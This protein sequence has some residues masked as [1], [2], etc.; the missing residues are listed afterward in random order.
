MFRI[1][2]V[3]PAKMA[4]PPLDRDNFDADYNYEVPVDPVSGIFGD[5]TLLDTLTI[6]DG[7]RTKDDG[8]VQIN[9]NPVRHD[10]G[11]GLYNINAGPY[12]RNVRFANNTASTGGG[13]YTHSGAPVLQEVAF[14]SNDAT[15]YGTNRGNGA[16]FAAGGGHPVLI[17][18][19]FRNNATI[20][21]DG[22]G[23]YAAGGANVLVKRCRF[24]YNVTATGSGIANYGNIW[25]FGR[26]SPSDPEFSNNSATDGGAAVYNGGTMK[27]AGV[28]T[29]GNDILNSGTLWA[30]GLESAGGYVNNG[31]SLR[32]SSVTMTN[33]GISNSGG[34]AL[35]NSTLTSSQISSS[36][37]SVTV[38][39]NSV[40]EGAGTGVSFSVYQG[41]PDPAPPVV[42]ACVLT[43]V[44]IKNKSTGVSAAYSSS[45]SFHDG[46]ANL[47]LNNVSITGCTTA[48]DLRQ[49][50]PSSFLNGRKGLY[51]TLNNVSIAG[52]GLN[53]Q[54]SGI[55]VPG[56]SSANN[57]AADGVDLS[58]GAYD[59]LDLRI[60]NS[61]IWKNGAGA[62]LSANEWPLLGTFHSDGFLTPGANTLFFAR[63]AAGLFLPGD[64]FRIRGSD[65]RLRGSVNTV[66]SVNG[67]TGEVDLMSWWP[68]N[69]GQETWAA[70]DFIVPTGY[71]TS[72]GSAGSSGT[73][74]PGTNT[75][76]LTAAQLALMPPG[77]LFKLAQNYNDG[78]AAPLVNRVTAADAASG[79]ITFTTEGGGTQNYAAGWHILVNTMRRGMSIGSWL[80]SAGNKWTL[81]PGQVSM[82]SLNSVFHP[83]SGGRIGPACTVTDISGNTVTFDA[84][85]AASY[86]PNRTLLLKTS[87]TVTGLSLAA[88]IQQSLGPLPEADAALFVPGMTFRIVDPAGNIGASVNT[89]DSVTLAGPASEV[90]FTPS[91]DAGPVSGTL[92]IEIPGTIGNGN[93]AGGTLSTASPNTLVLDPVLASLFSP[94][95]KFRLV[96]VSPDG[97]PKTSVNETSSVSGNLLTFSA[98]VGNSWTAGDYIVFEGEK[99]ADLRGH[100]LWE[101]SLAEGIDRSVAGGSL[102]PS[103]ELMDADVFAPAY[104]PGAALRDRGTGGLNP[105]SGAAPT[106]RVTLLL[107]HCFESYAAR[108]ASSAAAVGALGGARSGIKDLVET[109]LYRWDPGSEV[110]VRDI[111]I[112][113]FLSL[114]GTINGTNSRI[115][116]TAIDI[117]AY[118]N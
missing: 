6:Q 21:G 43:N 86:V 65:G 30:A 56:P 20:G 63:H 3:S 69:S 111:D 85:S 106:D 113:D 52:A 57:Y 95:D 68:S 92:M 73:L 26:G 91:L 48:I 7:L 101:T 33:A 19:D 82:L 28:T 58:H 89:V 70:G 105:A 22:A 13:V 97:A 12:L 110:F 88:G 60:R 50:S 18:C 72:L 61:V 84:A 53:V 38:V 34:M 99:W 87:V 10:R 80:R 54:T 32:A 115:Q 15:G 116:G 62:A 2:V 75:L 93:T 77:T 27:M 74:S 35:V 78:A 112:R 40:L 109:L 76:R 41:E 67:A 102:L 79:T 83:V 45:F 31:G 108:A 104:R 29:N 94:G 8:T 114:D 59:V 98:S 42:G 55:T 4:P 117:G 47:L 96:S 64:T 39:A 23:I 49:T 46:A 107:E 9:G 37:A 14:N 24:K 118:D 16:A 25:V 100:V 51:V 66:R 5:G 44:E 17:E 36:G 81:Q 11:A 1:V 103:S 71:G 90:A